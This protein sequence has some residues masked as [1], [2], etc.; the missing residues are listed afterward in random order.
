[1]AHRHRET[2]IREVERESKVYTN[3]KIEPIIAVLYMLDLQCANSA[4][5]GNVFIYICKLKYC[6]T[7]KKSLQDIKNRHLC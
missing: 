3:R 2:K 1:M 4:L 7:E 6:Y 5:I